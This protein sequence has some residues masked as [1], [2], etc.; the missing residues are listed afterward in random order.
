MMISVFFVMNEDGPRVC[1]YCVEDLPV[2]SAMDVL[3]GELGAM[4]EFSVHL[5]KTESTRPAY[6][7]TAIGAKSQEISPRLDEPGESCNESMK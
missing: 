6:Q 7:R 3:H 1:V 5:E 2:E 4:A